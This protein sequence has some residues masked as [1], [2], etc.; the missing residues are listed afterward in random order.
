MTVISTTK[1]VDN[2]ALTLV[3]EFDADP[4]SGVG[5]MGGR[6][7]ARATPCSH[8][9]RCDCTSAWSMCGV[10]A[11]SGRVDVRLAPAIAAGSQ[12]ELGELETVV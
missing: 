4:G 1:D 5:G 12:S 2:L 3:A 9:T 6:S 7:Q 8:R 11:D 10:A